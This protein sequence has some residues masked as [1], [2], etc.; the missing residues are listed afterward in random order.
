MA[1]HVHHG[2]HVEDNPATVAEHQR[3]FDGF[4]RFWVYVF[5]A[6]IAILIFLAIFNT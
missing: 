6:A 5:G 2:E 3:T 4:V 1:E